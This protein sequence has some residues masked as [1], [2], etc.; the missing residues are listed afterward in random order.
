MMAEHVRV[1]AGASETAGRF[2]LME[3]SAVGGGGPPRH[4][5]NA[6]DETIYVLEGS[7]TVV[8]DDQPR[9][10][11]ARECIVLPRGRDHTYRVNSGE[12]RLLVCFTPAGLEASY[13]EGAWHGDDLERLVAVAAT[14][15]IEV[16]GPPLAEDGESA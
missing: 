11:R 9:L 13:L 5:H 1:L 8:L 14:Y 12:A 6:E 10:V 2:V 4:R 15:G 7:L 3:I 16:T